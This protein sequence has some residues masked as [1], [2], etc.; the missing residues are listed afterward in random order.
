[1][2]KVLLFVLVVGAAGW[3]AQKNDLLPFEVG[4][5]S[6]DSAP[7]AAFQGFATAMVRGDMDT[8]GKFA[9]EEA[10]NDQA[11]DTYLLLRRLVRDVFKAAYR[12]DAE[13]PG[14]EEGHVRL[15]VSQAIAIDPVG[16]HSTFGTMS[17]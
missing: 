10:I 4:L 7:Y 8:V 13:S 9:Y 5:E 2:K 15:S 6:Q 17:C 12:L 11:S 16:V 3:Y 1:M 14:P